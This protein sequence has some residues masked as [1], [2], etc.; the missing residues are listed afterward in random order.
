MW[1]IMHLWTIKSAVPVCFPQS[2]ER[3]HQRRKSYN[4]VTIQNVDQKL[5]LF[6]PSKAVTVDD[7]KARCNASIRTYKPSSVKLIF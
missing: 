3:G 4:I 1:V 5:V 2:T 6:L 7:T